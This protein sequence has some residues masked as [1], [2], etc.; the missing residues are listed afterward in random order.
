MTIPVIA[1][2]AV[3]E[4]AE[5][6]VSGPRRRVGTYGRR[7]GEGSAGVA[8][9]I[10]DEGGVVERPPVLRELDETNRCCASSGREAHRS[11]TVRNHAVLTSAHRQ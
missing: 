7:R 1:T 2:G 11:E 10:L 9:I 3:A 5:Q 4:E 8:A 6:L